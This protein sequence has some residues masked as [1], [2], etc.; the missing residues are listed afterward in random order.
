M[1]KILFIKSDTYLEP[2]KN[3]SLGVFGINLLY[4]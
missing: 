4:L 3:H 1:I 2:P